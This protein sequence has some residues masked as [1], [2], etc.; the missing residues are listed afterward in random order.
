MNKLIKYKILV[1]GTGGTGTFFL[2]EFARYLS[3]NNSILKK[4]S[5]ITIADG[6]YVEEKNLTRQAFL[7]EDIGCNKA[8][9][10]TDV[11][12][13][14]FNIKMEAYTNFIDDIKV[15]AN[16]AQSDS[17]DCIPV[18]I[19]C[20]DN[21]GFRFLLEEYFYSNDVS[22][23]IIMDAANDKESGQCVY[24]AK[25][26][27]KCLSGVRSDYFPEMILEDTR[28]VTEMSCEELNNSTPQHI[29][30]NMF[31]SLQLLSG[32]TNLLEKG[33]FT[34]GVSFFNTFKL[35][36]YFKSHSEFSH[37][38]LKKLKDSNL[39]LVRGDN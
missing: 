5:D 30:T 9:V 11:I 17:N 25:I 39:K 37:D 21:H 36:N 29:F 15:L 7:K 12:Y 28:A 20:V 26:K 1:V 16:L 10:M 35:N 31:S 14:N 4:I 6:D 19:G 2:K 27:D 18:I 3:D 34:L 38:I 13:S 33:E 8:L 32:L 22:N 24:S 23:L